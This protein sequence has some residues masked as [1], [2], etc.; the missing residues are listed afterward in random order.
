MYL[1]MFWY[2]CSGMYVVVDCMFWHVCYGM[3]V[4]VC[5]LRHVCRGMCVVDCMFWHVCYGM[6]V[7]V[8]M[9]RYVLVCC[10][11]CV[12]VCTFVCCGTLCCDTYVAVRILWHGCSGMYVLV[13]MLWWYVY[14]GMELNPHLIACTSFIKTS[15]LWPEF[16]ALP[17]AGGIKPHDRIIEVNGRTLPP[18][19]LLESVRGDDLTLMHGG[20]RS[21][22]CFSVKEANFIKFVSFMLSYSCLWP[23]TEEDMLLPHLGLH[24]MR[25][26]L[27]LDLLQQ[28]LLQCFENADFRTATVKDWDWTNEN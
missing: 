22:A 4:L 13:C 10:G 21:W 2:V 27:S 17:T 20:N 26:L 25:R 8:C 6:Y 7:L 5:M 15:L 14:S 24:A 11:M 16:V 1:C 23:E 3:Y 19:D 18:S 12:V 9:L 28:L